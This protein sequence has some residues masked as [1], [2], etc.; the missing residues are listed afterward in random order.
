V[1]P[2]TDLWSAAVSW[3]KSH[4]AARLPKL[5]L[6]RLYPAKSL[7]KAVS[8]FGK[9]EG[10]HVYVN[11]D[12]PSFEIGPYEITF[13]NSLPFA[14]SLTSLTGHVSVGYQEVAHLARSQCSR[15]DPQCART[16][17]QIP[18]V[19]LSDQQARHFRDL[20]GNLCQLSFQLTANLSGP[21]GDFQVT[22]AINTHATIYRGAN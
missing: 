22:Q 3:L 10:P 14:L 21:T 1:T 17:L 18:S 13:V 12:R 8:I 6:G 20:H 4:A 7:G 19:N 5:I 15:L 9:E 2:W 11:P 16:A